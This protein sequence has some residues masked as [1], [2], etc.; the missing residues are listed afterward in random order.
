VLHW[1]LLFQVSHQAFF[2]YIIFDFICTCFEA[3]RVFEF[4]IFINI[5]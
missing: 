2:I 5:F 4:Q 1:N 3:D